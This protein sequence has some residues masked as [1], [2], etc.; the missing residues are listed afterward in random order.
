MF[1]VSFVCGSS[2]LWRRIQIFQSLPPKFP[3][4]N[5]FS[6]K[7]LKI[8]RPKTTDFFLQHSLAHCA[9][10]AQLLLADLLNRGV[11]LLFMTIEIKFPKESFVSFNH[12]ASP[13]V[14][15]PA[16]LR[17][18]GW[19]GCRSRGGSSL[20]PACPPGAPGAWGRRSWAPSWGAA[21]P[22][23]RRTCLL[24]NHTLTCSGD[25]PCPSDE[26]KPGKETL[27]WIMLGWMIHNG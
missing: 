23:R 17:E 20:P 12:L 16:C 25:A 3:T 1:W 14:W 26:R 19:Q 27:F 4:D 5:Y 9:H 15:R 24:G 2:K 21:A 22:R 7:W 8:F 13:M 11:P 10:Y 18:W 6:P